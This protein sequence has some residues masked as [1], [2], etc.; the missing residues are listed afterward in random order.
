MK[1]SFVIPAYNE[2]LRIGKCLAAVVEEIARHEYE[3]EII[4]VNN[5]STD[6]TA[7]IASAIGNVH[8]VEEPRKGLTRARQAGF[9]ASTGEL[10]ANVD[11]DTML[12]NGWL[13]TVVDAFEKDDNL[14]ALSGPFIYHDASF[15]YGV[16]VRA[17]YAVGY[18]TYLFTRFVLQMG[19]MLQGGNFVVRKSALQKIGGFDT[20]IEFYGEDTDVARRLSKVLS[21]QADDMRLILYGRLLLENHIV[22]PIPTFAPI[23]G[24]FEIR[25]RPFQQDHLQE[26][27]L[28]SV[29]RNRLIDG[30]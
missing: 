21:K 7:A 9:A 5:A 29:E 16:W 19:S 6:R 1:I 20:S 23:G 22:K 17:F 11:A 12:P 8:V 14:V 2:E 18:V 3:T 30:K 15:L 4:V 10:I 24:D 25:E 28:G 13:K 26:T 27:M